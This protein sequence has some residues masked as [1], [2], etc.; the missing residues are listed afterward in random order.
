MNFSKVRA[1]WMG[2]ICYCNFFQSSTHW[3]LEHRWH[4]W[5]FFFIS[6]E[7]GDFPTDLFQ[8]GTSSSTLS[9]AMAAMMVD[10]SVLEP[11]SERP[12]SQ[13]PG[14]I[15]WVCSNRLIRKQ[16]QRTRNISFCSLC[17]W[18]LEHGFYVFRRQPFME[19]EGC[20]CKNV[21]GQL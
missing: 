21:F 10:D 19:P 14:G 16:H 15:W 4:F 20:C 18:L 7:H 3:E 2:L 17:N 1:N 13:L 9:W 8:V 6:A 12:L 5:M 11:W